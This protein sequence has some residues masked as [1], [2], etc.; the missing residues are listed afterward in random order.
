[1]PKKEPNVATLR[2]ELEQLDKKIDLEIET[3]RVDRKQARE[4]KI[5]ITA[6]EKEEAAQKVTIGVPWA[7]TMRPLPFG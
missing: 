3:L 1:M 6:L 5:Q 2:I 7:D 4:L